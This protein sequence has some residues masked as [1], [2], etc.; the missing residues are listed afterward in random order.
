MSR[1]KA[2]AMSVTIAA[3]LSA[4]GCAQS[5]APVTTATT[6]EVPA[7]APVGQAQFLIHKPA[8]EVFEA[9]VNP[10]ITTKFWFV[11]GSGRLEKGTQVR[12]EFPGNASAEV[13]VREL[14]PNRRLLMDWWGEGTPPTTVEWIVTP[15]GENETRLGVIHSGFV[16][17]PAVVESQAR[18]ST[19]GFTL[20]L[21]GLKAWLEHDLA[22]GLVGDG[23]ACRPHPTPE[24]QAPA[25]APAGRA[26]L[27]IRKPVAEVFEAMVD[28]VLTTKFWF[29]EGSDRLG[30][31]K[32]VRWLFP[33]DVSAQV[34]VRAFEPNERLLLE[35]WAKDMTPQ[36]MEW[37][38]IPSGD[39]A[40]CV[41][42]TS[43]SFTGDA[44]SVADQAN[45]MTGGFTFVLTSMKTFLEHSLKPSYADYSETVKR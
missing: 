40:T 34:A 22:L 1:P 13:A 41:S 17:D 14:E 29:L 10:E 4:A 42:V 11:R 44:A 35:W 19:A 3:S 38:F 18:E 43:S 31:S 26:S 16:G 33:G 37:V 21:A 20:V 12:W 45:Y 9:I 32:E 8:T 5:T 30:P 36:T 27:L 6:A 28:P 39:G 2:Y 7:R 25:A 23:L 15:V 24:A